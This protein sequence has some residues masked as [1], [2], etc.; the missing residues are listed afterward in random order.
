MT[1]TA[2]GPQWTSDCADPD[3]S[4]ESVTIGVTAPAINGS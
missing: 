2:D 4:P 3:P 1:E